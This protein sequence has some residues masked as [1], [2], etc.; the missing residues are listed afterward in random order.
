MGAIANPIRSKF[1]L[2]DPDHR[3]PLP[4]TVAEMLEAVQHLGMS[5]EPP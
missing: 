5:E 1:G 2:A 3:R 4:L